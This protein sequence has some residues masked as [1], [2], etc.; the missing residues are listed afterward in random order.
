MGGLNPLN[1][2]DKKLNNILIKNLNIYY[3]HIYN[4][5]VR[6]EAMRIF[7][8]KYKDIMVALE[9]ITLINDISNDQK[10]IAKS[11][12]KMMKKDTTYFMLK[13][14]FFNIQPA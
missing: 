13:I 1:N 7:I 10:I 4:W 2:I 5:T 8:D 14:G 3:I 12:S 6:K 9:E 11:Y